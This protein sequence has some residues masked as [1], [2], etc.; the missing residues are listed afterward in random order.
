MFYCAGDERSLDV[1]VKLT[2]RVDFLA[3]HSANNDLTKEFW[4]LK[5]NGITLRNGHTKHI[6]LLFGVMVYMI[7][8]FYDSRFQYEV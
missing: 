4:K 7:L 1:K 5:Q 8:I 2:R 6:L 3:F